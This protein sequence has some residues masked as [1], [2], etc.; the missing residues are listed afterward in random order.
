MQ[1]N[2]HCLLCVPDIFYL[3]VTQESGKCCGPALNVL[4]D[5]QDQVDIKNA[6]LFSKGSDILL[7]VSHIG[8]CCSV[9]FIFAISWTQ[10]DSLLDC[11]PGTVL[12]ACIA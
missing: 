8:L 11:E 5:K 1:S 10:S 3:Y 6:I 9:S 7:V 2:G 12:F 4:P